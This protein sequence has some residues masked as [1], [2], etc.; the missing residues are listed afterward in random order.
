MGVMNIG[1]NRTY[2]V[3]KKREEAGDENSIFSFSLD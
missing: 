2:L 1:E 3:E